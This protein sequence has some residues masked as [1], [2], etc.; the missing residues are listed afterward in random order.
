[1]RKIFVKQKLHLLSNLSKLGGK[2]SIGLEQNCE[3]KTTN[4]LV[5]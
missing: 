2:Y 3:V 4:Y 5:I 1:M